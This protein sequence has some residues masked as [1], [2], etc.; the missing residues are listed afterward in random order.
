MGPFSVTP[1]SVPH[2]APDCNGFLVRSGRTV[3]FHATDVGSPLASIGANLALADVATLEF[4]HDPQL[5]VRSDRA[6]SL[7][8]RIRGPSGHLSNFEAAELVEKYA[9]PGLK[10]VFLAH[11]SQECNTPELACGELSAALA[12]AGLPG[13]T[14]RALAR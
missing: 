5:L 7:K 9:G 1:F 12:R 2:D 3:Y 11:L 14:Y 4:N 8:R 6:E 13:V 10:H